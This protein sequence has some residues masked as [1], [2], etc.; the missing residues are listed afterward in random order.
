LGPRFCLPIG[1]P[2]P[3]IKNAAARQ[4]AINAMVR[5]EEAFDEAI[6]DALANSARV[7]PVLA[8]DEAEDFERLLNLSRTRAGLPVSPRQ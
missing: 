8:G 1:A 6:V 7:D 3:F 2:L 5:R 4:A